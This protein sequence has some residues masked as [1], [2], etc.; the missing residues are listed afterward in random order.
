MYL[1]LKLSNYI[2]PRTHMRASHRAIPGTGEGTARRFHRRSR[3][4]LGVRNSI[5]V[6]VMLRTLQCHSWVRISSRS[7]VIS[8]ATAT[9]SIERVHMTLSRILLDDGRA[10]GDLLCLMIRILVQG[11]GGIRTGRGGRHLSLLPSPKRRRRWRDDG[12]DAGAAAARH[13]G[14]NAWPPSTHELGGV[15]GATVGI[16]AL[17]V[18]IRDLMIPVPAIMVVLV[19]EEA[20]TI[21]PPTTTCPC[22]P[23]PRGRSTT[24]TQIPAHPPQALEL[25]QYAQVAQEAT[26][27]AGDQTHGLEERR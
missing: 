11:K 23:P 27:V 19:V 2:A 3:W 13:A 17:V 26:N 10:G 7:S 6:V 24:S 12:G 25:V 14:T 18:L 15:D 16:G 8:V 20:M 1:S 22:H 4:R 21:A 5:I 9:G